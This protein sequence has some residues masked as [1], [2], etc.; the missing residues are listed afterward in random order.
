MM[1]CAPTG[2]VL[3]LQVA[4][5]LLPDPL[6]ATAP[7]P[8]SAVAFSVKLTFPVGTVPVTAAVNVTVVPAITGL[9]ELV[10]FTL[11]LPNVA[12]RCIVDEAG[13]N[14]QKSSPSGFSA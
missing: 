4:I 1:L 10:R 11:L 3:I 6:S 14:A 7:H 13:S 9:P 8:V 12:K 2:S 5:L